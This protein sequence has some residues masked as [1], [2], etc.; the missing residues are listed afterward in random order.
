[1]RNTTKYNRTVKTVESG[2]NWTA[3]D[4]EL[5]NNTSISVE[6]RYLLMWVLGRSEDYV[7]NTDWLSKQKQLFGWGKNKFYKVWKELNDAGHIVKT[8][9]KSDGSN[10]VAGYTYEIFEV[11]GE[12]ATT[13]KKCYK[14]TTARDSLKQGDPKTRRLLSID[15]TKFPETNQKPKSVS[16]SAA[17]P[18]L[19][20]MQQVLVNSRT[21]AKGLCSGKPFEE[22]YKTL[23]YDECTKLLKYINRLNNDVYAEANYTMNQKDHKLMLQLMEKSGYE[24]AIECIDEVYNLSVTNPNLTYFAPSRF[25]AFKNVYLGSDDFNSLEDF[26]NVAY[27]DERGELKVRARL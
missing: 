21:G 22:L 15:S 23:R 4:S 3:Y 2:R 8:S 1:M 6:A 27:E 14:D 17:S 13:S 12:A 10:L 26:Y 9:I 5:V 7:I 24:G 25:K 20:Y 19:P 16:V 11:L 18:D